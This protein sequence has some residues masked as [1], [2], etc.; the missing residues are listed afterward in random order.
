MGVV[1][2]A[3]PRALTLPYPRPSPNQ[4]TRTPSWSVG[5][6][7]WANL[8]A[9]SSHWHRGS[10]ARNYISCNALTRGNDTNRTDR[11]FALDDDTYLPRAGCCR[12]RARKFRTGGSRSG[13]THALE[14]IA[15]CDLSSDTILRSIALPNTRETYL[16][17]RHQAGANGCLVMIRHH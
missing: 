9:D 6:T 8:D 16:I 4:H 3:T 2:Q 15:E 5:A 12:D 1:P 13:R 14:R 10:G 7:F 17:S 11:E